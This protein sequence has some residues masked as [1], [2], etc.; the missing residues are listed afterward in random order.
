M[1]PALTSVMTH[2]ADSFE[3]RVRCCVVAALEA[4][5]NGEAVVLAECRHRLEQLISRQRISQ[6]A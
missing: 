2:P 6:A 5:E 3:E 1:R 4:A